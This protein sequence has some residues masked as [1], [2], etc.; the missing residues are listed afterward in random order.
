MALFLTILSYA[1]RASAAGVV[2]ALIV[3]G[4]H[5]WQIGLMISRLALSVGV[6]VFLASLA[7]FVALPVVLGPTVDTSEKASL[8]SVG[9]SELMNGGVLSLLAALAAGVLWRVARWRLRA[10][11]P[12]A[13]SD[14]A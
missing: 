12:P 3:C 8:L 9:V 1:A 14:A 10:A 11:R 6:A 13:D 5:R 4:L 7:M 2:A